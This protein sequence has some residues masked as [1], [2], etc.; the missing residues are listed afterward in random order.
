MEVAILMSTYNGSSY[1]IE[2]IDSIIHQSFKEWKLYIRDDGSK[3]NTIGIINNY[4]KK[5]SRIKLLNDDIKHRGCKD[6]FLWLL[7]NVNADYY[8]FSDQDDVWLEDKVEY[9][10]VALE[11]MP[12]SL[13]C[14]VATDLQLVDSALNLIAP[15]MWESNH[16][17][18]L[19]SDPINLQIAPLYPGCSIGFNEKA[20]IQALQYESHSFLSNI[21]HDQLILLSSYK[22][23]GN[24]KALPAAKVLYRQHDKNVVGAY[25]GKSILMSKFMQLKKT[26]RKNIDYYKIAHNF[27]GTNLYTY[28]SLKI[29]HLLSY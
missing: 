4:I 7:K 29:K 12:N 17:V 2:Q 27:L 21:L 23:K 18:K 22:A 13:P 24:I 1:I 5:D 15:S 6:S 26:L 14:V 16:I 20:K 28:L 25:V 19:V 11:S 10:L 8:F 9:S 3:D